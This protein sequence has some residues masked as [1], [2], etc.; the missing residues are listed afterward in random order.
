MQ[1]DGQPNA[2]RVAVIP[3]PRI[4]PRSVARDRRECVVCQAWTHN[5]ILVKTVFVI[6]VELLHA[7][8]PENLCMHFEK[9]VARVNDTIGVSGAIP[10]IY[11][12]IEWDC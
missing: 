9:L 4:F 1:F 10:Q 3:V 5:D 6:L 8:S 7:P 11:L 2:I 12:H